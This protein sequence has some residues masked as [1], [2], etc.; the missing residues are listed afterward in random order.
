MRAR[1]GVLDDMI[2][3]IMVNRIVDGVV[4][5]ALVALIGASSLRTADL[6]PGAS[7]PKLD[8]AFPAL[9]G[10]AGSF[11]FPLAVLAALAVFAWLD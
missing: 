2:S 8:R 3:T 9:A 5:F 11:A 10:S 4:P 6:V 7:I 1:L